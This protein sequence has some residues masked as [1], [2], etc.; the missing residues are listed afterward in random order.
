MGTHKDLKVWQK[1]I[2]LVKL[3]YVETKSFPKEELFG[4][5][6]Q[7]RRSAVSIPS[8]IAEG[9]GRGSK[10]ECE[11]FTY[12]ALGSASELETQLIISKE[13]EYIK[14]EEYQT[15]NLLLSE[16]IKMLSALINSMKPKE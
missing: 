6:S 9:F 15:L 13:L 14:N 12:I 4:L 3:V 7:M 2:N 11:H 16:I 5:I 10:K 1:S 8:N